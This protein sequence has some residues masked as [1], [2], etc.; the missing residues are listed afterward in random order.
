MFALLLAICLT[1]MLF[2]QPQRKKEKIKKKIV[3]GWWGR[4]RGH[5]PEPWWVSEKRKR[6]NQPWHR[7]EKPW[8]EKEKE[9]NKPWWKKK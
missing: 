4:G 1:A 2:N 6:V 5:T 9:R 7:K 3:R 8:W